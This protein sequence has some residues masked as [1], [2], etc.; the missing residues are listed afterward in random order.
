MTS[1][2]WTDEVE[3]LVYGAISR[4]PDNLEYAPDRRQ[5]THDILT[6]LAE[7]GALRHPDDAALEEF[8]VR[9][10]VPHP[11][12]DGEKEGQ[13]LTHFGDEKSR[14]CREMWHGWTPM[15]RTVTPWEPWKSEVKP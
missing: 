14:R 15:R 13:I 1:P 3:R 2:Q 5:L 6:R 11:R 7:G 12:R 9:V 8:A 4:G 10:D